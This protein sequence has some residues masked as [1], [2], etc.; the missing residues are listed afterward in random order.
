M[1]SFYLLQ[2]FSTPRA[3][4]SSRLTQT[5]QELK[6]GAEQEAEIGQDLNYSFSMQS[7]R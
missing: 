7:M 4:E 1:K 2:Q 6:S 5:L 3:D